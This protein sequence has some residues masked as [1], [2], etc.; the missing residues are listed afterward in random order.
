MPDAVDYP[1][2]GALP[3]GF[4]IGDQD[5]DVL[6]LLRLPHT[7]RA[8]L[9]RIEPAPRTTPRH[10]REEVSEVARRLRL[11]CPSTA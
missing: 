10:S 6:D 9:P 11:S 8:S 1:A 2:G 3:L 4:L 5:V 7:P